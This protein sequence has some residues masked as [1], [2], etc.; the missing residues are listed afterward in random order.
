MKAIGWLFGVT[1]I[2]P[3]FMIRYIT[4]IGDTAYFPDDMLAN[5]DS[6]RMLRVIVHESIHLFDSKRF[7]G[8]LFK[9]LYLFPQSLAPLALL[10][11]LAFWKIGFIWC[12]LFLLSIAPIP[13]P[14]RYWFELR[15]YRTQLMF[16]VKVDK[17]SP[18]Q[19]EEVYV[20]YKN[21]YVQ[22]FITGL[23]H[24]HLWLENILKT[25]QLGIKMF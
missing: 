5:P 13:A 2:S 1:K 14:F 15:A 21:N 20:G 8:P 16:S 18:E 7:F 4:T 12:L 11:L 22:T 9:F 23:G 25:K 19:L 10:S 17:A 3:E 6:E 24:F